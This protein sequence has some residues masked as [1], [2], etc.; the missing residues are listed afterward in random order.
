MR[1]SAL[2]L[3]LLLAACG[4]TVGGD[5]D[6]TNDADAAPGAADASNRPDADLVIDCPDEDLGSLGE[7][8]NATAL[9]E[10]F[11]VQDPDGPQIRLLTGD[12]GKTT[13]LTLILV[14]ARGAFAGG[15]VATGTYP[16]GGD[17]V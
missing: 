17:E 3:S 12:L 14:D 6:G 10:P 1:R 2:S 7:A 13:L 4:S 11:D 16:L 15:A 9:Q 8:V 5:D